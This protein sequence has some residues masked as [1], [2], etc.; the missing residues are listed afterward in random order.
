MKTTSV[1]C[2][3]LLL[4]FANCGKIDTGP[5]SA[6]GAWTYTTPDGKM[7]VTFDLVKTASGSLE[8]QHQTMKID[9]TTCNAEQQMVGVD[10]PVIGSIRINANDAKVTYPYYIEFLN[11]RVSSDFRLINA[12]T[13]EYTF[14]WGTKKSLTSVAIVRP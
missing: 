13:A 9:G 11:T 3:I 8:I 5:S 1:G 2:L 14:P 12:V 6:E 10:L 7:T 4:S